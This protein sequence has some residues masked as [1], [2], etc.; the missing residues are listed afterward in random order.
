[1]IDGIPMRPCANFAF[2]LSHPPLLSCRTS[3]ALWACSSRVA[4][5]TTRF[6]DQSHISCCS[7]GSGSGSMTQ[8]CG[9]STALRL[10]PSPRS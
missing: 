5:C 3:G 1:M 7:G 8:P 6:T 9:G 10:H 4:G 2:K